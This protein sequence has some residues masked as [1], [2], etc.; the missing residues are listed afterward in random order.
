MLFNRKDGRGRGPVEER[1]LTC[2][3]LIEDENPNERVKVTGCLS[4]SGI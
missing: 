4:E 1:G 3:F 2:V